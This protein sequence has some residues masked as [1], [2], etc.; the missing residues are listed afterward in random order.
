MAMPVEHLEA[1]I[2]ELAGHMAAATCRY[3]LLVADFDARRGWAQWEVA[4]C[5]AWLAWKC[6]VAPGTAREQVRVARAL[7]GLPVIRGEFAAGRFSYAKVRALTRI[8]TPETEADL[9]EMAECMTAGQLER[10]TAAHRRVS[11]GEDAA[12]H[13]ARR[14][15][16]RIN[17]DGTLTITATLAPQD[18]A[19]VLQALRASLG[20]LD[21]PRDD[22]DD[23][24]GRHRDQTRAVRLKERDDANGTDLRHGERPEV[25][26]HAGAA[27]ITDDAP[28]GEQSPRVS[29]E[30]RTRMAAAAGQPRWPLPHPAR[31]DRCHLEDGP[32][33]SPSA[34][35]LIGCNATISTMVHDAD[36]TVLA[37]GRRTRKPPPALR[38]AA[39]ERDGHRCRFPG[40]ES[41]KTDLHHVQHWANGGP[42]T[43]ANLT[44]LCRRHHTLVHDKGYVITGTGD[45]YTAKGQLI[46]HSPPLP[47]ADGDITTSH[48]ADITYHTIVPPYSGERLDLHE[49]IWICFA[50]AQARADHLE[51][52]TQ[53]A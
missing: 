27:A 20:D 14:L 30:T 44:C 2:C 21:H 29:P 19:V 3:L 35:Q 51:E 32:A 52:L 4:S 36:G 37:A 38:Q 46:P 40:C 16:W 18:G 12:R 10:F 9:A 41:R 42:T 48:D 5:A 1:R 13:R 49:A 33:I 8:A 43:L 15:T 28:T 7:T 34:L 25:I 17:G 23:E 47:H 53:A 6:Q 22:H 31:E 45:F 11:R 26:I 24:P 39:R 50:Q